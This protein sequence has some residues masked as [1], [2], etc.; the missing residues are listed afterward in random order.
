MT[1]LNNLL[2]KLCEAD[3]EFV[4]VDGF[5]A[6][7]H[8][9]ST[10][11]RDIDVCT[12]LSSA[13]IEKLRNIFANLNPTHRFTSPRLSFLDNPSPGESLNNLY[14]QTDLGPI[15]FLSHIDGVGNFED[16]S[17]HSEEITLYGT[18]VKIINLDALVRAK[19]TLGREKD[20]LAA[21][22]LRAILEKKNQNI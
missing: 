22:E 21:K 14:L 20:L 15:D 10:L 12:I 6:V 9:S 19:E 18:K 7:I 5:A 3:I 17:Q 11:T 2:Q 16:V 4:I 13:N 8:G 1:N